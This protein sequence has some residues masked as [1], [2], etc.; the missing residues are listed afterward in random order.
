M[1]IFTGG[2]KSNLQKI[3][4]NPRN[5]A[6]IECA[7]VLVQSQSCWW[8][9]NVLVSSGAMMIESCGSLTTC[10]WRKLENLADSKYLRDHVDGIQQL[11]IAKSVIKH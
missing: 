5:W 7:T 3:I 9:S 6:V 10:T 8:F 2:L 1:S 4:V 11:N